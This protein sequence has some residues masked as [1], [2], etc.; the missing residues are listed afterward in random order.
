MIDRVILRTE[1]IEKSFAGTHAL[2][3]VSVELRA[4]E[5][6]AL[7]GENGAGKSTLMNIISGVLP[8]DGGSVI[9]DGAEVTFA[10]PAVAKAAGVGFVHQELAL[11]QELSVSDNIFMGHLPMKG[12]MIDTATQHK[13]SE[14]IL[15]WF[16]DSGRAIDP[17]TSVGN[18]SVA[19]QQMVEIAKALSNECKVLIF[20]E[21]T[22]SLNEEEA[23]G[24][25]KVIRELANRGIGI[26]YISH[27]M[28]E[29]FHLCDRITV[30][31]DGSVIDTVP[32]ADTT[33]EYVISAMV[34]KEIGSLYPVK[35][36]KPAEEVLRVEGLSR[37]SVFRN[38]SFSTYRG[39]ILGLSGLVGAG[40]SEIAR[41]VC[42]IDKRTSGDIYL[43]GKKLRIRNCR[44]AMD[45]G[46]C[47]L[48]ENRKLDGLFLDMTLLENMV[49]PQIKT[50]TKNGMISSSKAGSVLEEYRQS[51]SIKYASH[52][53]TI[54][55]LSGGNQQKLMIGKLLALK[56]KVIFL[57][58]P[59][60]GIDVGAKA[61]I[62]QLLRTLSNEGIS[63]IVIS[64][65]M[66]ETVGVCDRVIVINAGDQVG[67]LSGENI[68][69]ENI[70]A[71]ISE[72]NE[73]EKKG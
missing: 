54:G 58:E 22:S 39:E 5:I 6:H 64:S 56:P 10:N 43:F 25:F 17:R 7:V 46:I 1:N 29:I 35:N 34:G 11:C 15:D 26:F 44:E 67:E 18:L 31:R 4:G 52:D 50:F 66:P 59:T 45:S 41:A 2:R 72:S 32:V 14:K 49:A 36:G 20:D 37:E 38:I 19:Q 33:S 55:S 51:M 24:L 13:A 73:K 28:A 3:G 69:Q 12:G 8:S 62:H 42:G 68:T 53:Q 16:G 60:R 23:A 70:I 61:E 21:P 27:K 40:R 65:E 9:M 48:T 63:V 57:D 71:M 47:Y 30:M